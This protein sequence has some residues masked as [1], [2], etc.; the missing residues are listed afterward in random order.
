VSASRL[1]AAFA[2]LLA[3][4]TIAAGACPQALAVYEQPGT[5]ILLTFDG[6]TADT[7]AMMHRFRIGFGEP[8][9][10]LDGVVMMVAEP[11]RPWGMIMYNCP[12]GDVTGAEIDA[13]TVWEG[14]MLAIDAAG[15]ES[16]I[17]V[18]GTGADSADSA[19]PWLRLPG[20]GA[21]LADS[22]AW[23]ETALTVPADLFEM[24]GCQ[25]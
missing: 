16:S 1:V 14:E 19:A 18:S 21:A 15:A 7:D 10:N 24:K 22:F 17:P 12:E 20:F 11:T 4:P 8:A 13:C 3:G 5:A 25:E 9:V 23:D 2:A 6:A